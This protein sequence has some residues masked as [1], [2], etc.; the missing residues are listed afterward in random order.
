M[1]LPAV[2]IDCILVILAA[3]FSLNLLMKPVTEEM[4]LPPVQL[5]E[6]SQ[7]RAGVTQNEALKVTLKGNGDD[8]AI[9][10]EDRQVSRE[11][12][13]QVIQSQ[14]VREIVIRGDRN[15]S[16][17]MGTGLMGYL[18]TLGVS[19]ISIAYEPAGG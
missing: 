3:T 13:G 5:P 1:K 17:G 7:A 19:G 8:V 9:L 10:M 6:S 4:T 12:L 2:Y 15:I 14:N 18:N 11:A 16:W